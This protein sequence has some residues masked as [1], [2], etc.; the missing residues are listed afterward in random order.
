MIVALTDDCACGVGCAILAELEAPRG[1]ARIG[2]G[3]GAI[4]LDNGWGGW[5]GW[6][7]CGMDGVRDGWGAGW[8]GAGWMGAGWMVHG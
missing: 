2:D 7:G 8:M 3:R 5:D 1:A 6:M 4:S